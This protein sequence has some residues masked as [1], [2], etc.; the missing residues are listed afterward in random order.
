M[1]I[2]GISRVLFAVRITK[3]HQHYGF[4]KFRK[5]IHIVLRAV[6]KILPPESAK[7]MRHGKNS[8]TAA[9]GAG[10][11]LKAGGREGRDMITL[12][13]VE[14]EKILEGGDF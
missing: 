5:H 3:R 10:S 8:F 9:G 6:N 14:I 11:G 1:D 2:N 12:V 4:L 13:D 7:N